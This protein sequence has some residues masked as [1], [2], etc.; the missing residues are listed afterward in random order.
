MKIYE[1]EE[2]LD[3]KGKHDVIDSRLF[4][5]FVLRSRLTE[6]SFEEREFI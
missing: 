5:E 4:Y 2:R 6:S 1:Q 3:A